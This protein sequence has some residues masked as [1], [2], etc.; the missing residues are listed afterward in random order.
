MQYDTTIIDYIGQ[1]IKIKRRLLSYACT[2]YTDA[3]VAGILGISRSSYSEKK[4]TGRFTMLECKKLCQAF[5][6]SFEYLFSDE[7]PEKTA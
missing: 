6:C 7:V 5:N 4:K 1:H 2:K 3:D